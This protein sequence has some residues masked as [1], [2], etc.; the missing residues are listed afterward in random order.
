MSQADFQLLK[1]S[2]SE[3]NQTMDGFTQKLLSIQKEIQ[4]M[5]AMKNMFKW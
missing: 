2:N 1:E 3:V 4:S 5:E